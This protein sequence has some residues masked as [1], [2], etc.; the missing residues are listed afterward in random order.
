MANIIGLL[1]IGKS[2][3][4]T[5][6]QSI[7]VTG[8][9]IANV[10]TPG[11][12]RQ[13]VNLAANSPLDSSPG[14][15]GDGVVA[16]DIQR[17]YDR[18]V[19]GRIN[20]EQQGLG[21]WEAQKNAMESVEIAFDEAGGYG[22]SGSMTEFW[23]AW[24]NLSNNPSGHTER[25][26]L[27]SKSVS[28]ASAFNKTAA[29]LRQQ[30]VDLDTVVWGGVDDINALAAEIADLNRKIGEI[31]IGAQ[32]AN[33]LRDR[34][35]LLVT[36]LAELVDVSTFEDGRGRVTVSVANGRPLVENGQAWRLGTST[37]AAGH[38]D[39]TWIDSNGTALDISANINGG[40]LKGWLDVRDVAI[41]DYLTRLDELAGDV[42]DGVNTRHTAGFD[43][44]AT[45]GQA[46][47]SGSTAADIGLNSIISADPNRVAAAATVAG[48]PGDNANA[49][50]M[51]D[52]QHAS[53]TG[54]GTATFDDFYRSLVTDVGNQ[55]R[56][57]TDFAKHQS[58][59]LTSLDN[60]R[61]SISGVSLEEEMLN[62][63]KF[64]HAFDAAAKLVTTVDEMIQTMMDMT[65]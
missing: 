58:V 49:V 55:V 35:D 9:N 36:R 20:T 8:H 54:G 42:A 48:V 40:K 1:D 59:M 52:L 39:V 12:T 38:Q 63:I 18:Y 4:L 44:Y 10:N 19:S 24:Q 51:A 57:A 30:Q 13:R 7:N 32:N 28:L 22:L 15:M 65:R 14:Q 43:L 64:Q 3:L 45:A 11:Y 23:N 29:G 53:V 17:V 25:I 21:R 31:E 56:S 50:A 5:H 6:Q 62:L 47:F 2:A 27:L 41:P 61:E 33:D 34:R 16:V 26:S 37:N 60:Y 46:F